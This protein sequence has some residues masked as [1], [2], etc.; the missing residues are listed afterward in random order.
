MLFKLGQAMKELSD[1]YH[2]PFVCVNQVSD[3][4]RDEDGLG[5][6]MVARQVIP[7]LGL[8]WSEQVNTRLLLQRHEENNT[9]N[10]SQRIQV[11]RSTPYASSDNKSPPENKASGIKSLAVERSLS[12]VLAPH[13]PN[14]S[15]QFTVDD[16]GVHG[17]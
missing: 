12:V 10:E 11:S 3:F 17:I 6:T 13:L 15:C 1:E 14:T 7:A 16:A 9:L 5:S 8:A 4:V 2:T